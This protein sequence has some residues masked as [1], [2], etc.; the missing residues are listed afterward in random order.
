MNYPSHLAIIMDGNRRW[1]K[2][3]YLPAITGYV[4]GAKTA[5]KILCNCLDLNIQY[6]TLFA[7]S[8][9]NWKRTQ[10]KQSSHLIKFM[11]YYL[12][13]HV[14][15]FHSQGIKIQLIGSKANLDEK[16][17]ALL[18]EVEQKT[19]NN[20]QLNLL[21][22]LDYG[23]KWDI[24][25]AA[26]QLA[27]QVVNHKINIEDIDESTFAKFLTTQKVP[28]PELVIRTGGEIRLSN[29]LLWQIAYSEIY[30]TPVFWPDF[31][32]HELM[33]AFASFN[34]RQQSFGK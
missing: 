16:L 13:H 29:F 5:W 20:T 8:T 11:I 15:R 2:K 18:T 26:K 7:F 6:L 12:A 1:A 17:L 24:V 4:I 30:F 19:A 22:A 33:K 21:I 32:E 23:G 27:Q 28:D 34:E 9:E 31:D 25:N 14:D 10:K 3:R